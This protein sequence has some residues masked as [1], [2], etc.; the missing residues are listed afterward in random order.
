MESTKESTVRDLILD[1]SVEVELHFTD[2]SWTPL[3]I[4]GKVDTG[5]D[6]CSIDE[7]L[8]QYL[9]WKVTGHRT[10]KS[11]LGRERRDIVKGIVK[12]R[13]LKFWMSATVTDRSDLSHPLLVGH[14]VIKDLVLL[15]E[16][17][18]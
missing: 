16:E 2:T 1:R 15:E 5:A 7:T 6:R 9:G 10:V 14:N 8:A 17:E 18:E 11:S 13:G 12:I 4:D 3:V